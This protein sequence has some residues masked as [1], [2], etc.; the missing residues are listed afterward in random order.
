MARAKR[1]VGI[2]RN[3]KRRPPSSRSRVS[4]DR[5]AI[6]SSSISQQP[7]ARDVRRAERTA[8][9]GEAAWASWCVLGQPAACR[10]AARAGTTTWQRLM[11]PVCCV[12]CAQT[13][14]GA[15]SGRGQCTLWRLLARSGHHLPSR[16]SVCDCVWTGHWW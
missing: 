3:L 15:G 5:R 4:I 9:R 8:R 11:W 2:N 7:A 12:H 1:T 14:E 10:P 13:A 16:C 6:L